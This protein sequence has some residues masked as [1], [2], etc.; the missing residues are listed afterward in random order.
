MD[1]LKMQKCHVKDV[2]EMA[3]VFYYSDAVCHDIP[4]SNIEN[5]MK[6]AVS[7][8]E[9]LDG[10]IFEYDGKIAGFGLIT[11]YFESECGGVCVQLMDLFVKDEFRGRGI[12]K[13]Y[14]EFIF[15]K[16]SYARRFRLEAAPDNENAMRLYKNLGFEEI[17]YIQMI[18]E[19]TTV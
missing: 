13:K 4:W 15:N 14:F 19:E 9:L 16:Y 6:E 10:Y 11:K 1:I 3:K 8:S 17:S 12:A 7:D 18:K 2:E 5:T